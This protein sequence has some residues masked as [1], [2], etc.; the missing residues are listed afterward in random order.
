MTER[1]RALLV[2][3]ANELLTIRRDRPGISAYWVLPGG[4]LE[5]DDPDLESGLNREIF[6]ELGGEAEIVSL[7][8]ILDSNDD[9][10]YIYVARIDSWSE[11]DRTGPEFSEPGRGTYTLEPIPLKPNAWAE[12]NL[13]PEAVAELI[14]SALGHDGGL[15]ALPDLRVQS[16]Q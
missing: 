1:V 5:P 7:A 16:G 9:R 12:L 2:T 10:Q 14:R 11:H 4:H 15:F 13:K 3:P 8:M 6:E